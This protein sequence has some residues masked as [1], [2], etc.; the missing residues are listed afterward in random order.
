MKP[1]LVLCFLICP[2]LTLCQD[3]NEAFID[4]FEQGI[5]L[6]DTVELWRDPYRC[7]PLRPVSGPIGAFKGAYEP[8]KF[9]LGSIL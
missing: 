4:G 5:R 8:A 3:I 6:K 1:L 2:F 7:P 9:M